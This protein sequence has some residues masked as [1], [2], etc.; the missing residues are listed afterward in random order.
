MPITAEQ[1]AALKKNIGAATIYTGVTKPA[2]KTP[3]TLTAGVPTGGTSIGMTSGPAT[4]EYK[5]EYAD[6]QVEQ[7][8]AP[9]APRITKESVTLKFRS[10]EAVFNTL[11]LAIQSGDTV[12]TSGVAPAPD[13]DIIYVGGDIFANDP[14]CV[15]LVT[16][17][18]HFTHMSTEYTLYEFIVLYEVLSVEG[19]SVNF[20]LGETRM[21]DVTLTGYADVTRPVRDQ[22]FQWGRQA[23]PTV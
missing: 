16:E 11:K 18:G 7:S 22:L 12:S 23:D 5:P 17:I 1:V 15:A 9:V 20:K 14:Q 8:L 2:D 21:V 6:V 19:V 10:A 13:L 3:V 4:F